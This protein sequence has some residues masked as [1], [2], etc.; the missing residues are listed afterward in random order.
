MDK[1]RAVQV[2]HYELPGE[3]DRL[4]STW[5]PR[6]RYG[7]PD[8]I[9]RIALSLASDRNAWFV[10]DTI[11]ADGATL[12]AGGWYRIPARWTNQPL[13]AQYLESAEVNDAP[14]HSLNSEDP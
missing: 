9:A 7:E 5:I 6:G 4:I 8:A 1:F 3:Y 14:S 11:A 12:A 2:N 13:L 10:G